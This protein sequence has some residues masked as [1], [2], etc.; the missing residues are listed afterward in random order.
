[1][2]ALYNLGLLL[3]QNGQSTEGEQYLNQA[4]KI[5]PSLINK[6]PAGVTP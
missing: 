3:I 1:V 4:I 2:N 6:V 5:D